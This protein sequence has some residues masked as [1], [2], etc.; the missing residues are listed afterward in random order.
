[1]ELRPWVDR[2]T[3]TPDTSPESRTDASPWRPGFT[4]SGRLVQDWIENKER[5]RAH[6]R[7]MRTS[8]AAYPGSGHRAVLNVGSRDPSLEL[9]VSGEECR[10][11]PNPMN[12]G[13]TRRRSGR[14]VT[15]DLT[16]L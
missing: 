9:T 14:G 7:D 11:E 2:R 10:L 12:C 1:M 16:V 8:R 15:D 6:P 3:P 5:G 4:G 13:D